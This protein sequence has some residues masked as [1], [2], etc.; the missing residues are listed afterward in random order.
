M[1]LHR[2]EGSRIYTEMYTGEFEDGENED[3]EDFT[4]WRQPANLQSVFDDAT[5]P[6][7]HLPDGPVK[8]CLNFFP[9]QRSSVKS[10]H[11]RAA[12]KSPLKSGVRIKH[13]KCIIHIDFDCFYCQVEAIRNPA[14]KGR[15][16]GVY[17]KHIVVSSNYEARSIGVKKMC[18]R[19]EALKVCPEMIMVNGEDLTVYR[20]FS[21]KM[22]HI[23][24]EF[25]SM[26]ERIGFDEN[27][28]DVTK[29]IDKL[30]SKASKEIIIKGHCFGYD[31]N[32]DMVRHW[33]N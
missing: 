31:G 16:F 3:D 4:N 18:T 25:S 27:F 7:H 33:E 1:Y 9:S 22:F 12:E 8:D 29:N 24:K 14:L 28:I 5:E 21:M 23:L 2:P 32:V 26:V 13:G 30:Q 19:A 11:Q 15:P 10:D 17:Q 20:E 6:V